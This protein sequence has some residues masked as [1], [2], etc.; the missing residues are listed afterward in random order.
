MVILLIVA[1]LLASSA[2]AAVLCATPKKDGTFSTSVK[3]RQACKDNEERLDPETLGLQGPAGPPGPSGNG[4]IVKDAN[5]AQVGPVMSLTDERAVVLRRIGSATVQLM[6]NRSGFEEYG[7]VQLH[8]ESDNCT[9]VMLLYESSFV[10]F[11][12]THSGKAYF[13][14][15]GAAPRVVASVGQFHHTASTCTGAGKSFIPPDFCCLHDEVNYPYS[16]VLAPAIV[17]DLATLGL[18]PPFRVEAP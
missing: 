3:I 7:V 13:G 18:V 15:G 9:G 5:G 6:V 8:Y 2:D 10:P 11:A 12:S 16:A 1:L 4:V 14:F 17:I